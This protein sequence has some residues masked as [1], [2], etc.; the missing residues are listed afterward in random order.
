MLRSELSISVRKIWLNKFSISNLRKKNY[1]GK[2][3]YGE[4][5]LWERTLWVLFH[6][7]LL[8]LEYIGNHHHGSL[9]FFRR[10]IYSYS[11]QEEMRFTEI[12]YIVHFTQ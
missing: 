1:H 5:S 7:L 9:S 2:Q 11:V 6:L 3:N 10:Y 4:K 8:W 12:P